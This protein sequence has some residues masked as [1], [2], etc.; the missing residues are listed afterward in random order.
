M[1]TLE[2][3]MCSQCQGQLPSPIPDFCPSC[4]WQIRNPKTKH[5]KVPEYLSVQIISRSVGA[6]ELLAEELKKELAKTEEDPEEVQKR[7]L[8]KFSTQIA[9]ELQTLI[10]GIKPEHKIACAQDTFEILKM[11]N[12]SHMP[13]EYRRAL[14]D[15]CKRI[16]KLA[17]SIDNY[18]VAGGQCYGGINAPELGNGE[19][20]TTTLKR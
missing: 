14:I 8:D 2:T 5:L 7:L 18:I 3:N 17:E 16:G 13:P 1:E 10:L 9:L 12:S 11:S 19:R 15:R 6:K 20:D 4:Q